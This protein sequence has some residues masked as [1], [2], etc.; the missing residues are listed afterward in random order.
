MLLRDVTPYYTISLS[1]VFQT[2]IAE[3]TK[4]GMNLYSTFT[5]G[6]LQ[7]VTM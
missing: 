4:E 1:S 5:K 6:L 7:N 2:D 3:G